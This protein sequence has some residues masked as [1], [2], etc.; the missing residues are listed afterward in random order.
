MAPLFFPILP[1]HRLFPSPLYKLFSL[2]YNVAPFSSL[3]LSL[4]FIFVF[5]SLHLHFCILYYF[6]FLIFANRPFC[7]VLLSTSLISLILS[8]IFIR[9]TSLASPSFLFSFSFHLRF[10][11]SLSASPRPCSLYFSKPSLFISVSVTC[12]SIQRDTKPQTYSN[13]ELRVC[14]LGII[15]TS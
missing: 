4:Y 6:Y 2:L 14:F 7:C 15:Y 8:S 13:A 11:P 3:I 5:F 1:P 10:P 9:F 12:S